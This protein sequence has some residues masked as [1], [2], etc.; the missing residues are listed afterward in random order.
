MVRRVAIVGSIFISIA[1]LGILTVAFYPEPF[2]KSSVQKLIDSRFTTYDIEFD[3]FSLHWY[4][5][6]NNIEVLF[7]EPRALDPRGDLLAAVPQIRVGVNALS[8]IAGDISVDYIVMLRPIIGFFRT[9]GGAVKFDIGTGGDKGTSG[10]VLENLLVA[11]S[12]VTTMTKEASSFPRIVIDEA[13]IYLGDEVSGVRIRIPEADVEIIPDIQGVRSRYKFEIALGD[14]NLKFAADSLYRT[15]DQGIELN[16]F[17]D[18]VR[19]GMLANI[20]PNISYLEP[21]E[22]PLSGEVKMQLNKFL[23]IQTSE[24]DLYG[25]SGSFEF[26]D[27]TGINLQVSSIHTRGRAMRGATHLIVDLMEV[28]LADAKVNLSGE[29]INCDGVVNMVADVLLTDTT[30]ASLMP[31]W[32]THLEYTL[33]ENEDASTAGN[34]DTTL[35]FTGNY[36][37]P[38]RIIVGRGG[39][40]KNKTG[41]I[42]RVDSQL[43]LEKPG[44]STLF[45]DVR[46]SIYESLDFLIVPPDK[47][48]QKKLEAQFVDGLQVSLCD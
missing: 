9:A 32:F 43:V 34:V 7:I 39:I 46:G 19:V 20:F 17:L 1:M 3:A 35:A 38:R 36:D 37:L 5:M 48:H 26:A 47:V 27:Y 45:F 2:L 30:L 25:E 31:R 24:F 28:D 12:T 11:V 41:G 33:V 13:R 22:V 40:T 44:A 16:L 29:F 18:H 15:S 10:V 21:L 23:I 42:K 4:P 14:D 6:D 8:L